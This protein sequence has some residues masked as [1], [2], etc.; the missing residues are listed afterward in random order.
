MS[1]ARQAS[2]IDAE[3][4][5]TMCPE[6]QE[7]LRRGVPARHES[8]ADSEG[9]LAAG[10]RGRSRPCRQPFEACTSGLRTAEAPNVPSQHRESLRWQIGNVRLTPRCKTVQ[11][12]FTSGQGAI[13]EA[14]AS[15]DR[16]R[17]DPR[18][19]ARAV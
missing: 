11:Q 6:G 17:A 2:A 14:D 12:A 19:I 3:R 18:P 5:R 15:K 7:T 10:E 4:S 9:K 13:I 16:R 1:A 8:A